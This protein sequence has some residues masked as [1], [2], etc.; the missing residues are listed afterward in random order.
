MRRSRKERGRRSRRNGD[1][2]SPSSKTHPVA[3]QSLRAVLLLLLEAAAALALV[4]Y[5]RRELPALG[6][7][8]ADAARRATR[9]HDTCELTA[10]AAEAQH[11]PSSLLL[12]FSPSPRDPPPVSSVPRGGRGAPRPGLPGSV[13]SRKCHFHTV[14]GHARGPSGA[15]TFVS[16]R[17]TARAISHGDNARRRRRSTEAPLRDRG[18]GPRSL[19]RRRCS[20]GIRRQLFPAWMSRPPPRSSVRQSEYS[21]TRGS[22]GRRS[23]SRVRDVS[24]PYVAATCLRSRLAR[25]GRGRAQRSRVYAHPRVQHTRL[26]VRSGRNTRLDPTHTLTARSSRTRSPYRSTRGAARQPRSLA[27]RRS[28]TPA[29]HVDL[30]RRSESALAADRQPLLPV[31][32][33]KTHVTRRAQ[34]RHGRT[35]ADVHDA[36]VPAA[37]FGTYGK[38]RRVALA[39]RASTRT[40]RVECH[41]AWESDGGRVI[42][43]AE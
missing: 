16:I 42:L 31:G 1:R 9:H 18:R 23:R 4:E 12:F 13:Y 3:F 34:T 26:S 15:A 27:S 20:E 30:R 33:S 7:G 40:S 14:Q 22:E 10:I 2:K 32:D 21:C 17:K 5:V 25:H 41:R 28:V 39:R 35:C 37:H 8:A 38:F 24:S 19:T 6:A 36:H 11:R 29:K 43:I